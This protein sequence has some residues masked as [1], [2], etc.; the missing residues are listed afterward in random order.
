MLTI[1][2]ALDCSYGA[3]RSSRLRRGPSASPE[4]TPVALTTPRTRTRAKHER[5]FNGCLNCLAR[6]KKCDELLPRC[7]ECHRLELLCTRR[8]REAVVAVA[9]SVSPASKSSTVVV[10]GS[11]HGSHF[12]DLPDIFWIPASGLSD[13]NSEWLS[14]APGD[15]GVEYPALEQA[16]GGRK[17]QNAV[18]AP[19]TPETALLLPGPQDK[20]PGVTR[21]YLG[22]VAMMDENIV[23][24]VTR[25]G[26][27]HGSNALKKR[28]PDNGRA[29]G[30]VHTPLPTPIPLMYDPMM[31][32]FL[33]EVD[34]AAVRQWPPTE[35][36]LLNHF[37]QHVARALVV[38]RDDDSNPILR[39]LVPRAVRGHLCM[40]HALLALAASHLYKLYPN[41]EDSVMLQRSLALS[42]LKEELQA[43]YDNGRGQEDAFGATV[44]LCLFEIC[45]GNSYKWILHLHGA[46][47]LLAARGPHDGGNDTLM[48]FLVELYDSI[49]FMA[50]LTAANVP[51]LPA[52]V[53]LHV[54]VSE[55]ATASIHPIF[56]LAKP[57]YAILAHVSARVAGTSTRDSTHDTTSA[58]DPMLNDTPTDTIAC[59]LHDARQQVLAWA[60]PVP[61]S[62]AGGPLLRELAA[63]AEAVRCA[64][65]LWLLHAARR[66]TGS[67]IVDAERQAALDRILFSI[68]R[69]RPGSPTEAQLLFPL[70]LAGVCAQRKSERLRIEY[71]LTVLESTVGMGNITAAHYFLDEFW[72]RWNEGLEDTGWE[73]LL[74]PNLVLW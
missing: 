42:H 72:Q 50:G 19:A 56:G 3:Q 1:G 9:S 47:A 17:G 62:P 27:L 33:D 53:L 26:H 32:H 13:L 64:A 54:A 4:D 31:E 57:L 35:Q 8:R 70:F 44:L 43:S 39:A 68:A 14:P 25:Q 48:L 20:D 65:L 6:R 34:E 49:L 7:G 71:R 24:D 29:H 37:V 16:G 36:H 11:V 45:Q 61:S 15:P 28:A 5:S 18:P 51:S 52:G 46:H 10:E 21:R 74:S 41:F 59:L 69:I 12:D 2:L 58:L 22:W 30:E 38:A 73:A 66:C 60:C 67:S 40:R 63:A 23:P 55:G